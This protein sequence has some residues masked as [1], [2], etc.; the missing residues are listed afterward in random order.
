[1]N[2]TDGLD[3]LSGGTLVF[4][5]VAYMIIALLNTSPTQPN[6]ASCAR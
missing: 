1:M 5:F 6:L 2:I 3:G 4:A